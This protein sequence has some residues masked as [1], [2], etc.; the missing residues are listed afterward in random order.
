MPEI[1]RPATLPPV[2]PETL[3]EACEAVAP[4]DKLEHRAR[5]CLTFTKEQHAE[6]PHVAL[7][8]TEVQTLLKRKTNAIKAAAVCAQLA[9]ATKGLDLAKAW[10]EAKPGKDRDAVEG[11][12][13]GLYREDYSRTVIFADGPHY[14]ARHGTGSSKAEAYLLLAITAKTAGSAGSYLRECAFS[15]ARATE[16]SAGKEGGWAHSRVIGYISGATGSV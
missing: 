6:M 16:L 1:M 15:A 13:L 9:G 12:A 14:Q 11:R 7:S 2:M 3:R 4:H 5:L 8:P 10:A